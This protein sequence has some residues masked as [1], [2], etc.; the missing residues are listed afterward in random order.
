MP[1]VKCSSV[2]KSRTSHR[3]RQLQKRDRRYSTSIRKST[4]AVARGLIQQLSAP[5]SSFFPALTSTR[6]RPTL[7]SIRDY[8]QP[9]LRASTAISLAVRIGLV[10]SILAGLWEGILRAVPKKKTS[11]RKKR[12]RFMAGKALQD[13]TAL[14]RCSACG[15]V[16]RA[17]LL[18]PGCIGRKQR[19][20]CETK[21]LHLTYVRCSG[22]VEVWA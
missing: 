6:S 22:Y 2:G 17:H 9:T 18:C 15:A 13:V 21:N 12:Q 20:F 1:L 16:K 11:H 19:P 14:N 7:T 10:P 5:F 4:M 8:L 3:A